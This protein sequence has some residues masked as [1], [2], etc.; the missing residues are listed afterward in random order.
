MGLDS[1]ELVMAFEEEF[2]IEI[3]DAD[4]AGMRTP[5]DVIDHIMRTVY[6]GQKRCTSRA[7]FYQ[8]RRACISALGVNRNQIRPDTQLTQILPTTGI[9]P[10]WIRLREAMALE[11][12]FWPH[13]EYPKPVNR[14]RTAVFLT[15]MAVCI[16]IAGY[17]HILLGVLMLIFSI[18]IAIR[19][20]SWVAGMFEHRRVILPERLVTISD[21]I[22]AV[23]PQEWTK[24][25]GMINE[26]D[27]ARVAK[28]VKEIVIEQ[29]GIG[30][31]Q[32]HVDAR[33]IEDL[34]VD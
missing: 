23:V 20:E 29:L 17:F 14:L 13:L 10:A 30:A 28:R 15:T 16:V 4:A 12:D 32:Y 5:R 34:G 8:F 6:G 24:A 2:G 11:A 25:E 27:S 9:Q 3:S 19:V 31:E 33:F 1:V 7:G 22:N 18:P 21:L 26:W